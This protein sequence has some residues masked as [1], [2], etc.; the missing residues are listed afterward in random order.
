MAVYKLLKELQDKMKILKQW[1]IQE[2][3]KSS[4]KIILD[5]KMT[6]QIFETIVFDY[7]MTENV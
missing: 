1:M 4:V 7:D 5:I 2:M 3:F 6:V